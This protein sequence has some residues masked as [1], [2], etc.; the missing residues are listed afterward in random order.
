MNKTQ[1][2]ALGV[3]FILVGVVLAAI[4]Q[5]SSPTVNNK[6]TAAEDL[7]KRITCY[8]PENNYVV[9]G[10]WQ[11]ANWT[12]P[13]GEGAEY[14]IHESGRKAVYAT[15]S[16][17]NDVGN[18]T[19]FT[20]TYFL[21]EQRMVLALAD[22]D[23]QKDEGVL[24]LT[25]AFSNGTY[26]FKGEP[27]GIACGKTITSGNYTISFGKMAPGNRNSPPARIEVT[28]GTVITAYPYY[29]LL[30]VGLTLMVMGVGLPSA[31]KIKEIKQ[32]KLR[33]RPLVN[34]EKLTL[35]K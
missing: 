1:A 26:L 33:R 34:R 31:V 20:L 32:S 3:F 12:D 8:I 23:V 17:Y 4:S 7:V 29:Y 10:I 25:P 22:V 6:T 16:V 11:N 18:C 30:P 14:D 27:G 21:D 15:L 35:Q 5:V 2:L 9:V 13:T 28:Y 24:D 19:A